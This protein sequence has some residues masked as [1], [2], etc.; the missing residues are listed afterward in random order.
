V[1]GSVEDIEVNVE[2]KLRPLFSFYWHGWPFFHRDT[3][4]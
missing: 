3:H 4:L 1:A 2:G